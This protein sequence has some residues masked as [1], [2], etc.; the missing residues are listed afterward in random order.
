[1]SLTP[2]MILT[3]TTSG[4]LLSGPY[5]ILCI[6][7]RERIAWCIEL[8]R[9]QSNGR[10]AGY[11]RAPV[12]LAEDAVLAELETGNVTQARFDAPG[13]WAMTDD[14]YLLNGL[15]EVELA[16]R[17]ERLKKRD[18]TWDL[19]KPLVKDRPLDELLEAHS[20]RPLVQAQ[21]ESCHC[22][23]PTVYRALH[24]FLA[25]GSIRNGLIPMTYRCGAPGRERTSKKP[26]GRPPLRSKLE[27]DTA[28][29][30]VLK[31]Q[32]KTR[33]GIAYALIL[34]GTRVSVAY[35]TMNTQFYSNAAVDADGNQTFTLR[36]VDERPTHRQFVYWGKKMATSP[37]FRKRNGLPEIRIKRGHKGGSTRELAVAIGQCCQFDATSVDVYLT[38][39]FDRRVKLP[40]PTRS[41]LIEQRST[42]ILA[43]YVSWTPS[44]A[45]TFLQTLYVGATDKVEL[46]RRF[47]ID[48][49][50]E[51]WPGMLCRKTFADNGEARTAESMAAAEHLG[52]DMEF[53]PSFEGAAKGDVESHHHADH[54]WLDDRLPGAT[55]GHARERG[56]KHPADFALW[57]YFE[58][59]REYLLVCIKYNKMEVPVLA[60][61][62]M[63]AE[64]VRPT[65]IN[66]L[67]WLLAHGQRADIAFDLDQ[68][69]AWTLPSYQGVIQHNG[70]VLKFPESDIR[71][72]EL[73]FFCD[74]LR[75]DQRF[76]NAASTRRVSPINLK[77]AREDLSQVW[78]PTEHGLLRVPNVA[79]D[80]FFLQRGTLA[81]LASHR[82][83]EAVHQAKQQHDTDQA[84]A[85]EA[86]RREAITLGAKE[87]LKRKTESAPTKSSKAEQHANLRNKA[88]AEQA[89][90]SSS[91]IVEN[92]RC[93]AEAAATDDSSSKKDAEDDDAAGLAMTTFLNRLTGAQ[94]P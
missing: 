22:S 33:I 59:M 16:R 29:C 47:G 44:S 1:M 54:K 84:E 94:Q 5:R 51:D 48:I 26:M 28:R 7:P 42:V 77:F 63:I 46:C 21:A 18:R 32:D 74:D 90:I 34:Q 53:A 25:H 27:P 68:V 57:N 10:V 13:H 30:Y 80:G 82:E 52:F 72:R 93:E 24:L 62:E 15:S 50:P 88:A 75:E 6:N 11:I 66:I 89:A 2:G 41:I 81:D 85:D 17:K 39:L 78:L 60:P 87:E 86:Q 14:D 83:A 35:A 3:P 40:P 70:I 37:E 69:R 19:I 91:R 92:S 61:T 73:R 67:K 31:A 38:S 55:H 64:G 49:G 43:P 23:L 36:P 4:S 76:T 58:Y 65:R 12:P 71:V 45:E 8:P 79:S 56:Q 20:L 9:F